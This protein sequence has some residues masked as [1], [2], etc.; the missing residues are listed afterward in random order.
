[1]IDASKAGTVEKRFSDEAGCWECNQR[2]K[3]GLDDVELTAEEIAYLEEPYVAHNIV[4]F[5]YVHVNA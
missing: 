1:M 3:G 4:G 2:K 5:D